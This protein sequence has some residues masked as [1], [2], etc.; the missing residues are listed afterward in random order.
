MDSKQYTNYS[1]IEFALDDSFIHWIKNPECDDFWGN[2]VSQH[3]EKSE[4]IGQARM[5]VLS[6]S[7]GE[8]QFSSTEIDNAWL[9]VH[10]RI[11]MMQSEEADTL[12][13]PLH[14]AT[15]LWASLA[16]IALSITLVVSVAVASYY[17]YQ[18]GPSEDTH[19]TITTR[20]G[21]KLLIRLMDSTLIHLN[22]GSTLKY[23]THFSDT[24][25]LVELT[26]EAFFEVKSDAK[27]P[28]EII[29]NNV[30]TKVVGTSFNINAYPDNDRIRIAVSEGKVNVETISGD[31][32]D[33]QS[34]SLTE[35]QMAAFDKYKLKLDISQFNKTAQTGWKDG[36]LYMEKADF[37][38]VV[39]TIER[40]FDVQVVLQHRPDDSWRFSGAFNNQSL[41]Y[42]LRALSYPNQFSYRI[43]NKT[44]TIYEQ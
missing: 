21:E 6:A 20:N 32:S 15:P 4:V 2:W 18:H 29:S 31:S 11:Q 37:P 35:N 34:V 17:F 23:P 3:P 36:I 39:T 14:S 9:K 44:V 30:R 7:A 43:Q 28:F 40:W 42:I 5:I 22:A 19:Q 41:E 12:I 26:G 27:R 38:T 13:K 25:R 8:I 10:S 33:Y 24:I 1:P 16:K